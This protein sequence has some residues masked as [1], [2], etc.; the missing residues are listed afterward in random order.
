[1][2]GS[3]APCHQPCS[4]HEACSPEPPGSQGGPLP[5]RGLTRRGAAGWL[6]G[7]LLTLGGRPAA[8]ETRWRMATEY[9]ASAMPGEGIATFAGRVRELSG[10]ELSVE[11]VFDAKAG[12]RSAEI[13]ATIAER[14][15][16]AGDAFAGA[17]TGLHPLFGLSS[18]PFVV[19]SLEDAR[20]LADLARPAY[21]DA[22]AE[23]GQVLLYT[24]PWPPTG[25]WTKAPLTS[26]AAL[27]ALSIRAYD[28]T[29]ADVLLRAGARAQNISFADA[30]ARLKDGS[31]D[32]VLSS[33][34]GGAGR[35]LWEFLPHFTEINYAI[36]LSLAVLDGRVHAG[37]PDGLRTHVDRAAA[38]TE[39]RQWQAL[40][41]R[42]DENY[43]RMRQNGVTIRTEVD[44]PLVA[45]LRWAAEAT[46]AEWRTKAGPAAVAIL[47]AAAP[48]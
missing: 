3:S 39:A 45:L 17:L 10:G 11:P 25:L 29:S 37:L 7:A 20:R 36:P 9:P 5:A 22:F 42:L 2:Q 4:G 46:V 38:E 6:G 48:R 23:R 12:F 19:R 28:A 32:A 1:M 15:I 14:R 27:R 34:D 21:R 35:N 26:V 8:A 24:T 18:L 40:R 33:G 43:A 41:T 16:E 44:P 13:L 30:M 47:D 31:V